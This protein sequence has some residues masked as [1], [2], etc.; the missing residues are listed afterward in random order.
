MNTQFKFWDSKNLLFIVWYKVILNV[1]D[2]TRVIRVICNT[3][4][5]KQLPYDG[6][7]E[8][9]FVLCR[10]DLF[11]W[12]GQWSHVSF[13]FSFFILLTHHLYL[14]LV[15]LKSYK[16]P[17]YRHFPGLCTREKCFFYDFCWKSVRS[18]TYTKPDLFR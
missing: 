17:L 2:L 6:K 14:T 15:I 18:L 5:C 12:K 13:R 1:F 8:S 10:N 3:P 7:D 16:K 4:Y 11:V 9:S